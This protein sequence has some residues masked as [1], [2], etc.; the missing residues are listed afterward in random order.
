MV[1][2][3]TDLV[4][5][6]Q[7]TDPHTSRDGIEALGFKPTEIK[8]RAG[9]VC[10]CETW[11]GLA[12]LQAH[13]PWVVVVALPRPLVEA[14][15]CYHPGT[16]AQVHDEVAVAVDEVNARQPFAYRLHAEGEPPPP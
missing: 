1:S 15:R 4:H 3:A 13:G 16:T 5:V 9:K 7:R 11:A 10:F 2:A 6:Y 14:S 12:Y 8:D